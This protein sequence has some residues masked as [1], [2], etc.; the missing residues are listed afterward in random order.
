M[1]PIPL[2]KVCP[3]VNTGVSEFPSIS[4]AEIVSVPPEEYRL[5]PFAII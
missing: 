1:V 3:F 5:V 2:I 4:L